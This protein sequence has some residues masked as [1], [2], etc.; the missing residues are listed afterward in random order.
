MAINLL[1]EEKRKNYELEQQ[2]KRKKAE[3]DEFKR[4]LS[5]TNKDGYKNI[6]EL[7]GYFNAL[8]VKA[9][10]ISLCKSGNYTFEEEKTFDAF[11]EMMLNALAFGIGNPEEIFSIVE[12]EQSIDVENFDINA[13]LKKHFE[14][15]R[16]MNGNMREYPEFKSLSFFLVTY[17]LVSFPRVKLQS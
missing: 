3:L 8:N 13:F 5:V 12:V 11:F 1:D 6:V 15:T 16:K 4:Q 10:I 7:E 17:V 9:D 14:T 2:H